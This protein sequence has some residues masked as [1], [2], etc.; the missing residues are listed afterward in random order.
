MFSICM[1]NTIETGKRSEKTRAVFFGFLLACLGFVN[2][3]T[4]YRLDVSNAVLRM[5]ELRTAQEKY[6][7]A[8]G[9]YGRFD[10]LCREG[11]ISPDIADG[12]DNNYRFE[13]TVSESKYRLTAMTTMDVPKEA[14][15]ICLFMDE[16][17]VIR[18][19]DKAKVYASE[20][21]SPIVN[22]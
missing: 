8:H 9:S 4:N 17:G 15:G 10:D 1:S 20:T 22:Q 13:L 16:T 19:T 7:T 11:M 12:L 5:K 2:C 14:P 6:R 18:A 3:D 21:S